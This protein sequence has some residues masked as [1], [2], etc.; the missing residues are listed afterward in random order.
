MVA[1]TNICDQALLT[2]PPLPI[3][4]VARTDR[5][6]SSQS[7]AVATTCAPTASCPSLEGVSGRA[8]QH[9]SCE[10]WRALRHKYVCLLCLRIF[11]VSFWRWC[12]GL[13]GTRQLHAWK[14][15]C[16]WSGLCTHARTCTCPCNR[17]FHNSLQPRH[18]P[19][20]TTTGL[21]RSDIAWSECEQLS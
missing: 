2:P 16:A 4:S 21:Q 8:T 12:A 1:A 14:M 18:Q 13:H 5:L 20:P 10:R 19:P 6:C 15:T 3:P 7:C 9:P 11:L 17:L